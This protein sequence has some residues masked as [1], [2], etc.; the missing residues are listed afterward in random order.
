FGCFSFVHHG[1]ILLEKG[2]SSK[3]GAVHFYLQGISDEFLKAVY[4][5][6]T[7]LLAASEGEGFGLP[8]IE[9]ARHGLPI[10][11]RDIAVFREV[12]DTHAFYFSGKE[13]QDLAGAIQDWLALFH[14]NRHPKSEGMPWLTWAQSADR[15]KRI[16]TDEEWL[17][18]ITPEGEI[19]SRAPSVST[20]DQEA[21]HV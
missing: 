5:A 8:L 14:A 6:S 9:A 7:C 17:Y 3:S 15:L 11:A 12:A 2:A 13:P 20:P 19:R 1:S 18:Q 16:L 4:D 10:I 21:S